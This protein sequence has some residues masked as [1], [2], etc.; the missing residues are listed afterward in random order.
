MV[1]NCIVM[2]ICGIY[3]HN[4]GFLYA[5]SPFLYLPLWSIRSDILL[6]KKNE[7]FVSSLSC[8]NSLY[9]IFINVF[10]Q[11]YVLSIFSQRLHSLP[12]NFLKN[13]FWWAEVLNFDGL[14]FSIFSLMVIV[15]R[16]L[17]KKFLFISRSQIFTYVFFLKPL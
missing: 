6:I 11:M 9:F 7:V 5:Y 4:D 17:C 12:V 16:V 15:F 14:I 2:W 8:K 1:L 13:V 3:Q 10:C